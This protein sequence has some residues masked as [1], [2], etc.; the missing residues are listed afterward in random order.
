[1]NNILSYTYLDFFFDGNV[2]RS[3]NNNTTILTIV[4]IYK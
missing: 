1:M 4:I 2:K 3:K